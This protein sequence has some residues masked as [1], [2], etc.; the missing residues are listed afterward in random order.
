MPPCRGVSPVNVPVMTF[1]DTLRMMFTASPIVEAARVIDGPVF[2]VDESAIDPAVFG[3][4]SYAS[5]TAIAPRIDRRTAMQVPAVKRCRDLIAGSIGGLPIDL[6]DPRRAASNASPLFSQPE[7]AVPRS[8]TMTRL[9]EDLLF[10]RIGWWRITELAWQGYPTQVERIEPRRVNVLD[11]DAPCTHS[12]CSGRVFIDG[13]HVA[14]A[15]VIRFDSPNDALLVAG[16]R[17]IRTCLALDSAASRYADGAPPVDYFTPAEGTDPAE[18]ADIV[19]MLDSWQEARR[20]RSTG[21]VPA[22]LKYNIGGWN[23]E[24]LQ[25][26]DARQHAVLEIARTCGVDPEELGVSTTSRTYANQFDRRKA[27]LDFTLG[28]Y[29]RAIEDRLGMGDV[30]PPGY[31]SR[32]N[33]S[34]FLR[35]DDLTRYQTY[36]AGL[37]VGALVQP[38][39]RQLEDRPA[40]EPTVPAPAQENANA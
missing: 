21:Y 11:K 8:V 29:M 34:A 20:A 7:A 12:M 13:T 22:A 24:Q 3:L 33:L 28:G 23:P 37:A 35:S 10:E 6:F 1:V 9:V 26:A 14:D 40:A 32:F 15:D 18:D 4:T 30:T 36:A 19:K 5:P 31:Y 27:F 2:A 25:L 16:A 38:E 39:I 17:A